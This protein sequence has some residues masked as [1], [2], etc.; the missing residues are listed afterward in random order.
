LA[1]NELRRR[2]A[3][4]GILA[5][6]SPAGSPLADA[7]DRAARR[8]ANSVREGSCIRDETLKYPADAEQAR[9]ALT[10]QIIE[11]VS[12]GPFE[13]PVFFEML[14]RQAAS[15]ELALHPSDREGAISPGVLSR[16]IVG[17]IGQ[18][19]SE[20][21]S[22]PIADAALIA[23]SA[24]MME[25]KYQCAKA[26][27]LAWKA[28]PSAGEDLLS[29]SGKPEDTEQVLDTNPYPV[30]LFRDTLTSWLYQG[31]PRAPESVLP[32]R[33]RR[34]PIAMLINSAERFVLAHEYGHV[35]MDELHVL[36]QASP[37]PSGANSPWDKEFAAD[38]FGALVA[39][40]SGALLDRLPANMA[41]EG[42]ELAMK[43]DEIF[44]E[45][46]DMATGAH[47]P[48][49]GSSGEASASHPP[50]PQRILV[51]EQLYRQN[52]PD[53]AVADDDLPGMRVP[54]QT[55]DQIWQRTR[56]QLTA[57]LQSGMPLHPVWRPSQ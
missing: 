24:G 18:P 14:A 46:L 4:F 54:A 1:R 52:H 48:D 38:T 41:L 44:D 51:L 7:L 40:E 28:L 22:A 25:F 19:R 3:E 43:T 16:I 11:R 8:E 57:I 12:P 49:A 53:P 17:T 55:L 9:W 2:Q 10:R 13:D 26:L 27:V 30:T 47:V 36:D 31:R 21:Y 15:V 45:V 39:V 20:A 37:A 5:G 23:V 6:A 42:A 34:T 29:F 33:A 56:P 35:L 50:F 32:A